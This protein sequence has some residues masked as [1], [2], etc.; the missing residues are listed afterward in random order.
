MWVPRSPM[1]VRHLPDYDSHMPIRSPSAGMRS[2]AWVC[3]L[4]VATILVLITV[5]L[6]GLLVLGSTWL[7]A[8]AIGRLTPRLSGAASW[9]AAVV[10]E[11][12]LLTSLS[13]LLH[14]ASPRPHGAA[15][16]LAALSLPGA[17]GLVILVGGAVRNHQ[18]ITASRSARPAIALV[19]VLASCAV[20]TWIAHHGTNYGVSWSM[21]GDARNHVFIVRSII[22]AGG[23]SVARLKTYPAA[24]NAI[25]ALISVAGGR[26]GLQ[27]GQLLLHDAEAVATTYILAG[28]AI[29]SMLVAALLEVL[30]QDVATRRRIPA[31]TVVVLLACAAVSASPLILGTALVGGFLTAYGTLPIALAAVVL[32]MRF[33]AQADPLNWIL[34]G[35][36]TILTLFGWTVLAVVPGSLILLTAAI[37]LWSRRRVI[38][39]ARSQP[40]FW[41]W[42]V[43]A[44]VSCGSVAITLGIAVTQQSTFRAQFDELGAITGPQTRILLLLGLVAFGTLIV[45][46]GR[47]L[48][49]QL[50]VPLVVALI[51]AGTVEWMISIT[52]NG[53]TWSYYAT[54]TLWLISS[55]LIWVGFVPLL[56]FTSNEVDEHRRGTASQIGWFLGSSAL[57][58]A[59]LVIIGFGTSVADPLP[60]ALSGW[61]QPSAAVVTETVAAANTRQPFVLWNWSDPP[62]DRLGDFWAALAWNST[63]AG[64]PIALRPALP[65]GLDYWAYYDTGNL[66]QLCPVIR[67]VP[68]LV[69]ETRDVNLATQVRAA[70][71]REPVRIVVAAP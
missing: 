67:S 16:S 20:A 65:G 57:S 27:S 18:E 62:D 3:S 14:L 42:P 15:I 48:K 31:A 71:R 12:T 66:S 1:M 21:S 40:N 9:A 5:G 35:C 36:T 23:L 37:L 53:T 34:L 46:R 49:L 22:Q 41:Q 51:G 60:L 70:C 56:H 39:A 50:L 68:D 69:I 7:L 59:I 11:V 29:A 8:A 19:I 54:K 25:T 26:A 55:C 30:P 47:L 24:I 58:L 61:F 45:T 4:L 28:I 44:A 33:L 2:L 6:P 52:A 13:A 10:S 64:D 38:R 17:I 32:A 63:P 43:A